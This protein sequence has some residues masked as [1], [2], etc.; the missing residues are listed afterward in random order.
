M[1]LLPLTHKKT[2][3]FIYKVPSKTRLISGIAILAIG[4]LSLFYMGEFDTGGLGGF[5]AG[6]CTTLGFVLIVTRNKKE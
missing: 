2:M 5:L 3:S 1:P 6:F 4:Q